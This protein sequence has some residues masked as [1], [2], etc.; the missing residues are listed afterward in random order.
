REESLGTSNSTGFGTWG[1]DSNLSFHLYGRAV[2]EHLPL[3]PA[4]CL[5]PSN[6]HKTLFA[7]YDSHHHLSRFRRPHT[8]C[9]LHALPFPHSPPFLPPTYTSLPT[10]IL[11][12]T[13]PRA[14]PQFPPS[15][16][17]PPTCPGNPR[18]SQTRVIT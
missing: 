11:P 6:T 14:S 16:S 13:A 9:P 4:L 3:A 2:Q 17:L 7:V 18:T 15:P 8:F 1:E 5:S 10:R 12:N